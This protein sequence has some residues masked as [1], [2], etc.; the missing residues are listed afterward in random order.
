MNYVI[1]DVQEMEKEYLQ[2]LCSLSLKQINNWFINER[3]RHW[4]S[5]GRAMY[6]SGKANEDDAADEG[7]GHA[8]Q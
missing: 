2:H 4:N 3:K 5:E 1:C 8:E 7:S 6:P